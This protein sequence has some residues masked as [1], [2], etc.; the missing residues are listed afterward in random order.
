[1]SLDESLPQKSWLKTLSSAHPFYGCF[2]VGVTMQCEAKQAIAT[3]W[4]IG[5]MKLHDFLN[6]SPR[7]DRLK[8]LSHPKVSQSARFATLSAAGDDPALGS[9]ECL[10]V[11]KKVVAWRVESYSSQRFLTPHLDPCDNSSLSLCLSLPFLPAAAATCVDHYSVSTCFL[12]P[13]LATRL[14]WTV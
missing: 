5:L 3:R 6:L 2:N 13:L 9:T 7:S 12:S 11:A 14:L 8:D 4:Q 10:Q 1:M